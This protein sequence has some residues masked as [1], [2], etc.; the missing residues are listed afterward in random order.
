MARI[1]KIINQE[2]FT[3][4]KRELKKIPVSKTVI[5]LKAIIITGQYPV[6][7]VAEIFG[8]SPRTIFRWV[9]KFASEGVEGLIDKAKGHK[10]G[11]IS[12]KHT[13][14]IERWIVSKKNSN[15][16]KTSWTLE[17]LRI[18]LEKVYDINISNTAIWNHLKKKKLSIK[19]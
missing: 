1:S 4:A 9:N 12:D 14:E 10:T 18:E 19:K 17:K 8:V 3:A 5:K 13:K 6:K 15:G 16:Q 11:K 2:V 7:Q